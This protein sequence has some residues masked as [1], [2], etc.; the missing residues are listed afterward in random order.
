MLIIDVNVLLYSVNTDD[1]RNE[2][3]SSWM[4]RHLNGEET[5]AFHWIT[6]IGF[7]RMSTHPKIFKKP[8]SPSEATEHINA[9]LNSRVTSTITEKGNHWEIFEELIDDCGTAG[10]LTTDAHL[11]ALAITRGATLVSCDY[12]FARFNNLRW[13]NPLT[14]S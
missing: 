8:L 13:L 9:W 4:E 11:A 14:A 6:L 7:L 12:D 2:R 10:N 3:L 1:D 5:V